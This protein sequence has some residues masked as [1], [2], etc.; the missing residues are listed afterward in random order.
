MK[1]I[2][3]LFLLSVGWTVSVFVQAE[4]PAL[5]N[6][7]GKLVNGSTLVNGTTNIIFRIYDQEIGGIPLYAETQ[8]VVAVDG[9]YATKIGLHAPDPFAFCALFFS[10]TNWLE[11]QVGATTLTPRER[12]TSTPYAFTAK[13]AES[14]SLD[15]ITGAEV[16]DGSLTADDLASNTFWQTTGN[17]G[18][19]AGTHFLGTADS[20][21]L[22][23][24]V[25]NTRI[26]SL[27]TN[28]NIIG[29]D[30]NNSITDS[31]DAVIAGGGEGGLFA[32]KIQSQSSYSVIGGGFGNVI[33]EG[34][35]S[36]IGGGA[37]NSIDS[38]GSVINGGQGN[39][40]DTNAPYSVIAGGSDNQID[41]T[42]PSNI[43]APIAHYNMILGGEGNTIKP[44]DGLP[45]YAVIIGG[46]SNV[47]N[48]YIYGSRSVIVGSEVS[49]NSGVD[50]YIGPGRE[51]VIE[52]NSYYNVIGGGFQNKIEHGVS[53]AV[54]P[55]GAGA[56]ART[57][58]QW[59]FSQGTGGLQHSI[60]TADLFQNDNS[61]GIETKA[62]FSGLGTRGYN[63]MPVELHQAIV[64][65]MKV[66][67][68]TA[69]GSKC[70]AYILEGFV[71]NLG[72]N[73]IAPTPVKQVLYE[74]VAGW[75]VEVSDDDVNDVMA[76]TCIVTNVP[77]PEFV[78]WNISVHTTEVTLTP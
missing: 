28:N 60:Q 37:A 57:D 47:I 68:T 63:G 62:H 9:L 17:A 25:N 24:R 75:D 23:I 21:P 73:I 10:S 61:V 56:V 2:C 13:F 49:T 51:H 50:S 16:L 65:S 30:P 72:G 12:F 15:A 4:V 29:G 41:S 32:N 48:G 5:I 42:G 69:G 44:V 14:V 71:Q 11:L 31:T 45:D 38:A 19:I 34:P 66:V 46:A 67:G 36:V 20:R 43:N 76:V 33:S 3:V 53:G 8:T 6:F 40:V 22:D 70:G 55:G 26:L 18:T 27:Q 7:Q 74:D 59:V 1:K 54:I 64:Y 77:D 52:T 35:N 39:L 78:Q 58:G